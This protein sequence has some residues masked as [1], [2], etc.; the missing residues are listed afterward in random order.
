VSLDFE[1]LQNLARERATLEEVVT[2]YRQYKTTRKSLEETQAML[3]QGLDEGMATLAKEEI[4]NL[5]GK[6]E[7]LL[8]EIKTALLPKDPA[9]KKDV[10]VEIPATPLPKV[11]KSTS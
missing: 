11:G 3:S 6:R 5:Q 1:R 7:R 4:E 8:Q 9:D 2:K 10:I